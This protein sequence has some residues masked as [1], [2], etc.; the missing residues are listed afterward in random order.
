MVE[1]EKRRP[2]KDL[3]TPYNHWKGGRSQVGVGLFFQF[4]APQFRKDIEM[5]ERI[6]RSATRLV[7]DLEHK[8][9]EER[10]RELEKRR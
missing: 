1:L 6:Q 8:P 10:L 7:K 5:L 9:Y 3:I 2:R 4:W